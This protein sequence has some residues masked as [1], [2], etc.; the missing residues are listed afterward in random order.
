MTVRQPRYPKEE[1]ARRGRELYEQ[2]IRPQVESARG[3]LVAIDIDTGDFELADTG[4]KAA[5]QL[6]ARRPAAQI[7]VERIGYRG[8]HRFGRRVGGQP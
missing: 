3:K 5:K 7:W 2:Q 1:F 4:L 8:V 6:L